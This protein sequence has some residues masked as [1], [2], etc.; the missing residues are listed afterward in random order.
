MGLLCV[1]FYAWASARFY[2]ADV[3]VGFGHGLIHGAAMP[4]ALPGLLLGQDPP[5][6]ADQNTGRSYKLGY[7]TGINLCGLVVFGIAFW[8]PAGKSQRNRHAAI[9]K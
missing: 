1:W 5:I 4:M 2:P 3:R 7:I 8:R 9:D 6:Y